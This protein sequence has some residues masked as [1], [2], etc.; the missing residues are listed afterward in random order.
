MSDAPMTEAVEAG[1]TFAGA[2][3]DYSADKQAFHVPWGRQ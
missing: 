1:D 3:A 2:V